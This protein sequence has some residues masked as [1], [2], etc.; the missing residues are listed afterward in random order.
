[1][2]Q[3]Q[4]AECGTRVPPEDRVTEAAEL[5]DTGRV[6][7]PARSWHKACL[8]DELDAMS[9]VGEGSYPGRE[10]GTMWQPH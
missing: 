8:E 3:P 6:V 10:E 4:C 2:P 7:H 1:M 5:D 9:E